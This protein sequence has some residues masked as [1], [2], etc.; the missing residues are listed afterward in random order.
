MLERDVSGVPSTNTLFDGKLIVSTD[1]TKQEIYYP[2]SVNDFKLILD[3]F[4]K[5][6]E[7]SIGT[8][9]QDDEKFSIK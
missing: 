6:L 9:Y 5:S 1:F 8:V 2:S 7:S 4:A 3:G